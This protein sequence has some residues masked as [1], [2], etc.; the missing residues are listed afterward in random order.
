MR[1]LACEYLQLDEIWGFIAKKQK[2]VQPSE[3]DVGDVWTFVAMDAKSRAV[4]CF[5][6]GERDSGINRI[7]PNQ[8]SVTIID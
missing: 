7:R 5:K 3:V 4:A 1:S 8:E 2:N 6:V